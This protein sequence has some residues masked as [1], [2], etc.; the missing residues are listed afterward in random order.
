MKSCYVIE[1]NF[2]NRTDKTCKL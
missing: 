1:V 2:N